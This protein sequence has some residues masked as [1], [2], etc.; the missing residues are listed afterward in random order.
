[1]PAPQTQDPRVLSK[2]TSNA[3]DRLDQVEKTLP[4]LISAI[5]NSLGQ[6]N[7]QLNSQGEV[8][9]AVVEL[10]G[11]DTVSGKI[12]ENR[13]RRATETMEAEKKALEELKSRGDLVAVE[14]VTEKGLIVGREYNPDGTV[15]HP[16]RAQVAFQRVDDQFKAGLK[17]QAVGFVLSLPNGGKFEIVEIYEVVEKKEEA[18]PAPAPVPEEIAKMAAELGAELPPADTSAPTEAKS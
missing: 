11:Q 6:M 14:K 12:K 10:L 2:R 15:R 16:G 5:N 17:D 4:S 18:P 7:G 8:L 1:M 13:E 9:E 3:L